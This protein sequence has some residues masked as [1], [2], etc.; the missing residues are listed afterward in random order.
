[1]TSV[2]G[3][4]PKLQAARSSCALEVLILGTLDDAKLQDDPSSRK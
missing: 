3:K 2:K 4:S 1:M